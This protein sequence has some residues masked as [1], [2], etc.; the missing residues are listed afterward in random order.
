[1]T[2]AYHMIPKQL[3]TT[4]AMWYGQRMS[5]S[6]IARRE[7]VGEHAI[8]QR[9]WRFRRRLRQAGLP[10]PKYRRKTV[11]RDCKLAS[12]SELAGMIQSL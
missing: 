2:E 4:A 1:M 12:T 9:L 10:T 6:D 7:G 11:H 5:L 3:R 8:E